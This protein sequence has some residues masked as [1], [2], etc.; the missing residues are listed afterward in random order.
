M[1]G[2]CEVCVTGRVRDGQFVS[3]C[4]G[5]PVLGHECDQVLHIN[6]G[7]AE[8]AAWKRAVFSSVCGRRRTS[9]L[10]DGQEKMEAPRYQCLHVTHHQLPVL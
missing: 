7:K 10:Q 2:L 9:H 6:I 8:T 5:R 3:V 4:G 1:G